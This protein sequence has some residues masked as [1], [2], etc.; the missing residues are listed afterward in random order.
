VEFEVE[1][2]T[3]IATH[4]ERLDITDIQRRYWF[5]VDVLASRWWEDRLEEAVEAARPRYIPELNVEVSAT[6]S[7]TALCSDDEW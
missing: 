2:A 3:N 5:D 6:R 4:L 1:W 7:I